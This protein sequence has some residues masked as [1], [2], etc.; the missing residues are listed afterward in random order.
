MGCS[1]GLKGEKG[2]TFIPGAAIAIELE[3]IVYCVNVASF[4]IEQK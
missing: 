2:N 4:S 1:E 3:N